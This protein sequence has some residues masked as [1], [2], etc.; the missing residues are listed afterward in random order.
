MADDRDSPPSEDPRETASSDQNAEENPAGATPR[1][2]RPA[3]RGP[4][5][6]APAT[7]HEDEG[8]P[9]QAT[10]NPRAAG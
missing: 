3:D 1:E 4:S 7:S 10:G 6:D 9:G 8:G 2:G 5:P